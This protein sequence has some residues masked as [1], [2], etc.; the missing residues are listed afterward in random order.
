MRRYMTALLCLLA[1]LFVVPEAS[2]EENQARDISEETKYTSVSFGVTGFLKDQ[3]TDYYVYS[4]GGADITLE[5]PEGMASVYLRMDTVYGIYTVTDN[6]TGKV[7][8][9]GKN[10]FIH[11]FIDLVAAFGTMPTSVT[12][13]FNNGTVA[14]SELSV[15]SQG[16]LPDHVQCWEAPLDG[17]ADILLLPTHGDDDQLYFAGVI[18]YYAQ[19]LDC[20]VQVVYMTDHRIKDNVRRHEML[21]GLWATGVRNYPVF[22]YSFDFRIDD[23]ELTYNRLINDL[24]Y[25]MEE[26]DGFMVEQLRRFKP[27]VVVAH[28][29][30][31][32]YGHG[33]HQVYTDLL[34]RAVEVS[35]DPDAFP[36]LARK[37]GVWDVPKTYLHLWAENQIVLPIDEP[38]ESFGGLT[39][40]Q[41]AQQIGFPCHKSQQRYEDYTYW[42]YGVDREI[43]SAAQ[44]ELYNPA[45]YGLYRTTVGP[46]VNRNDFME[47]IV[48]YAEQ[49]R[50]EAER[51]EQERLEQERLEQERLE[52]EKQEQEQ[53]TAPETTPATEATQATLSD[54]EFEAAWAEVKE[55]AAN[56]SSGSQIFL[57]I[58]AGAIL[59][60]SFKV[61]MSLAKKRFTKNPVRDGMYAR[62]KN[63]K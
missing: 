46:D 57:L 45:Y 37:Y 59:V 35:N 51:Q 47:N 48:T 14:I 61:S 32:E 2:A 50:L 16:E 27:Q 52:K 19:E 53:A 38:L 58:A 55:N 13:N 33:M 43:T 40:F 28:D 8:E 21:D 9:A 4:Y 23:K 20:A 31:G 39:A 54:E 26:L 49:A 6:S 41:V 24:D 34:M 5:N 44:I 10:G 30:N 60:V 15:F 11:D 22:G 56:D 63:K 1:I 18:P 42:L 12:L 17:C 3:R 7:Y 29:V 25:T 36:E 62:K